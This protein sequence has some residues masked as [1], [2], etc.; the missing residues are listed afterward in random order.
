MSAPEIPATWAKTKI[1]ELFEFSYGKALSKSNRSSAGSVPVYGSNGITGYHNEP[2]VEGPC[3]LVGRKGAAGKVSK[4]LTGCWPIDTT[5]YVKVPD[6]LDFEFCFHLFQVQRFEKFEKSTAIPSLS[7]DDAYE[8]EIAIPPL[9][10]QRRIVAKIEELFSE[11]DQGVEN[12]KQARAQLAVYRQ[13]LLKHAFEGHLT[14]AWRTPNADTKT[15]PPTNPVSQSDRPPLPKTWAYAR[16]G[17][18]IEQPTYGTAQKCGYD[19]PGTGVLRIPNLVSGVV[20][21]SDLK[22]A[23]FTPEEIQAYALIE[24]DLLIIRSNG[25]VSIV[26]RCAQ[27][28]AAHTHLLFAGYLIRLRPKSEIASSFL[29][30]QLRSHLVRVQIENAAKSTSGVNNINSKEI[31]SLVVAWCPFAEQNELL[32]TLEPMLT[33][34]DV[35][36]ADIDANLRKAEALRQA[37]LK[38][39]FAGELVPQDPAD[40]PPPALLARLRSARAAAPTAPRRGRRQSKP[41]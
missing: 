25:S 34:L 26:G 10:E 35:V 36:E 30:H 17:D 16:L 20:D 18:L 32:N 9:P 11:L 1:G 37:I 6:G 21:A 33:A 7:R 13:S 22:F 4:A 31:Q 14:A 5:Y 27:V 3:L 29:L 40:E 28:Q 39:A 8:Q 38:K 41:I 12:L 2:L 24:G 23:Q 15:T 19:T